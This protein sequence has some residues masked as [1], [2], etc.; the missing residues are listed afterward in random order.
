MQ[1][2]KVLKE[3]VRYERKRISW[4]KKTVKSAINTARMIC[5]KGSQEEKNKIKNK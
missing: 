5:G 3:R 2:R 1:E 4:R